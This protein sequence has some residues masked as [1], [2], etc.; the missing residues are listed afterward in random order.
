MFSY[1]QEDDRQITVRMHHEVE[2]IIRLHTRHKI[3]NS[4]KEA[5]RMGIEA[6]I[7]MSMVPHDYSFFNLLVQLVEEGTISEKRIDESVT[8]ILNLKFKKIT[9]FAGKKLRQNQYHVYNY[10]VWTLQSCTIW[11]K[12]PVPVP[13]S[14]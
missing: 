10:Q 2:D 4:P 14:D 1:L 6:G 7:D 13:S 8:R 9:Q 5:V 11:L 12:R 3:A